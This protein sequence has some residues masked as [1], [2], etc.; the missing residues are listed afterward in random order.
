MNAFFVGVSCVTTEILRRVLAFQSPSCCCSWRP[1]QFQKMPRLGKAKSST[2]GDKW[3]AS[4][5]DKFALPPVA[6]S[7]INKKHT[8][9]QW[10]LPPCAGKGPRDSK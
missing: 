4:S 2:S 7:A 5:L 3:V 9:D 8:L 6:G 10:A 1:L